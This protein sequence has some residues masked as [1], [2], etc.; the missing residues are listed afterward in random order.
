MNQRLIVGAFLLLGTLWGSSF[1]AIDIGLSY[2][3][4]LQFA[5]LRYLIAGIVILGYA[6]YSTP[7]WL[8]R[9]RNEW[10]ISGVA[11]GFLI[12]GHHGFL[13]LGQEHVSG[14]VAAVVVSLGPVLTALFAVVVLGDRLTSLDVAGFALGFFGV[15]LVAQPGVAEQ[16]SLPFTARIAAL[17]PG[18]L[19]TGDAIGVMTVLIGSACFALGAVLMRPIETD[20]PTRTIQAWAMLIGSALLFAAGIVRGESLATIQWTPVA[21]LSLM[22]LGTITGA[23][24]FLIYF[25]LLDRLGP[26][27]INLIG[28]L[29]PVSATVISC[30]VLG[31]IIDPLTGLGFVTIV[32]G[33]V[34]VQRRSVVSLVRDRTT[35]GLA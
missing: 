2:F 14:A 25:E 6:W 35:P 10:L 20:L 7:R 1:V 11:G 26:T 23:G 12:G 8:P 24:A 22:Y 13:Y 33:F 4:P 19:L 27:Q 31:Q 16:S 5:A 34:C 3:P 21:G 32:A 29:E 9:T 17:D 30:L 15:F 18:A 28:Y